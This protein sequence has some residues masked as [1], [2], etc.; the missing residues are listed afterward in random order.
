MEHVKNVLCSL[1]LKEMVNNADLINVT[2][3]KNYWQMALVEIVKTIQDKVAMED[4]AF[5]I[6]V[7]TN[8]YYS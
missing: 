2:I 6:L 1:G 7:Q 5:L 3:D 8:K 4:Y